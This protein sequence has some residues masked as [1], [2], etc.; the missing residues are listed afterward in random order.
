M[1]RFPMQLQAALRIRNREIFGLRKRI[2]A[3]GAFSVQRIY[4]HY[5][6]QFKYMNMEGDENGR[7]IMKQIRIKTMNKYGG[8]YSD[9]V[10]NYDADMKFDAD[11]SMP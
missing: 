6:P 9:I 3:S 1:T 7:S 5:G 2:T 11:R 10:G 4:P 8:E